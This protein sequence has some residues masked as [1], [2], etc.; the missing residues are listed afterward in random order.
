[1]T[2]QRPNLFK[3]GGKELSQDAMICW[4]LKWANKCYAETHPDHHQAG[5]NFAKALF[6]KHDHSGPDDICTVKLE[7]QASR[8]DVLAWIN[9]E[10]EDG[11]ALLI[12]DKTDSNQHSG[13]LGR[14]HKLIL[15]GDA[16]VEG[17]KIKPS[18]C[19]FFPIFLKTG[20]MSLA[21]KRT[22]Q[23]QRWRPPYRVFERKEFLD[24]LLD[25]KQNVSEIL[26]DF[27]NHLQERE[28]DSNSWKE[29]PPADWSWGA[30]EGFYRCL[31][32]KEIAPSINWG[33][34]HNQSGG[35]L[36]FWR[37]YYDEASG[38][39]V[40]WQAEWGKLCFK[41]DVENHEK[42]RERRWHWHERIVEVGESAGMQVVKPTRFGFGKTMTVAV[43]KDI[44]DWRQ[45]DS[46]GRLDLEKT[47]EVLK[48]AE[49]VLQAAVSTS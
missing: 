8:I 14:Y 19:R 25:S 38:D 7:M 21:D 39:A 33:Y 3:Y 20:N 44:A 41:I 11:Y 2:T 34:V 49:R 1:M 23:E 22:I 28:E 4:L 37:Y 27:C 24:S 29:T 40:Y 36:G 9:D 48:K 32:E 10:D 12:E 47:V 13:Q 16:Q 46:E 18:K 42:W 17:K 26:T 30:W 5:Q 43:P 31:E 45:L 35:F 6:R 15:D